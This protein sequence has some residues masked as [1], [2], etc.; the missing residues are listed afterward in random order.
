METL[1]GSDDSSKDGDYV[2]LSSDK[3]SMSNNIPPPNGIYHSGR[4][5][6]CYCCIDGIVTIDSNNFKIRRH[7]EG[8]SS[9]CKW[10]SFFLIVCGIFSF[11]GLIPHARGSEIIGLSIGL[12]IYITILV[13]CCYFSD[14]NKYIKLESNSLSIIQKRSFC[15]PRITVYKYEEL[16]HAAIFQITESDDYVCQYCRLALVHKSGERIK[17]LDMHPEIKEQQLNYFKYLV[18]VINEHIKI[19]RV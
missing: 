9:F 10:F 12:P 3:N 16:K 18:D 11:L 17:I 14:F 19:I 1:T 5:Y 6:K 4:S 8:M 2:Y 15:K 13:L 7:D